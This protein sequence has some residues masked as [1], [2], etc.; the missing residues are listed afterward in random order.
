MDTKQLRDVLKVCF[1]RCHITGAEIPRMSKCML[2]SAMFHYCKDAFLK[3][4]VS[5]VD[6]EVSYALAGR[7]ISYSSSWIQ[8]WIPL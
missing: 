7:V 3:D 5:H 4:D 2:P 6:L 1:N 8:G